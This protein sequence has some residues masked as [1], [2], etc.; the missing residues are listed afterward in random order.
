MSE[1]ILTESATKI[2]ASDVRSFRADT[3]RYAEYVAEMKVTADTV[4]D[5]VAAFRDAFKAANPKATGDEI[6]AY[7][8][9]VRNGLNRNVDQETKSP[10]GTDWLGLV[11]QA[12]MNAYNKGQIDPDTIMAAVQGAL[13]I[14]G[15]IELTAVA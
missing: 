3:K 10:K 8:T 7:A 4:K 1:I 5:H 6:K 12:A 2:I 9:K 13:F 14:D 15:K 11:R